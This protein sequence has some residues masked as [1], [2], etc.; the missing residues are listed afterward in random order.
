MFEKMCTLEAE[1][2]STVRDY[3]DIASIPA[4]RTIYINL[5]N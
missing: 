5:E 4:V 2:Q 1:I 3:G